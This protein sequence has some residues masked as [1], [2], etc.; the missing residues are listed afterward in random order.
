[1]PTIGNKHFS[2]DTKAKIYDLRGESLD[3]GN[4]DCPNL[5][6]NCP[7]GHVHILR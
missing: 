1:M 6:L 5:Y 3:L 4:V 2:Y 7:E